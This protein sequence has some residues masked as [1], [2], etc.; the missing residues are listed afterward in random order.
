ML[1]P[2]WFVY[3]VIHVP[4]TIALPNIFER[5]LILFQIHNTSGEDAYDVS[6]M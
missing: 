3:A 5:H 4:Q 1:L 2:Q 6:T